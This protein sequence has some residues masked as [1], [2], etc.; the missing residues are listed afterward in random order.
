[1]VK[2]YRFYKMRSA[3]KKSGICK[4]RVYHIPWGKKK[5]LLK[6]SYLTTAIFKLL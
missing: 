6:F 2:S 1:M 3:E 4:W 5:S